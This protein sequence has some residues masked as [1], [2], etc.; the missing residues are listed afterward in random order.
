VET[1]LQETG[2]SESGVGVT[3]RAMG[4]RLED[5]AS[6]RVGR[7]FATAAVIALLLSLWGVALAL[8]LIGAGLLGTAG[9]TQL[10]KRS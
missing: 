3:L 10:K 4:Q 5:L 8:A 2:Y 9:Y 7:S 6:W 1:D